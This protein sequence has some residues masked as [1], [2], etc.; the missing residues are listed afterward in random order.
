MGAQVVHHHDLSRMQTGEQELFHVGFKGSGI[1]R[2]DP[3]IMA[4][5]MPSS[6]SEAISVVCLPRLRGT[7]PVA[8]A[9]FGARAERGVSAIF[10][11][12]SS[13]KTK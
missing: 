5:P 9:P 3:G 2:S 10:E 11:P 4:A 13:T 6:E 8:R 7:L 1:G 12:H